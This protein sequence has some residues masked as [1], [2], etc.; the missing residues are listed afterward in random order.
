VVVGGTA[1][2]VSGTAVAG[3]APIDSPAVLVPFAASCGVTRRNA[4][5]MLPAS[6]AMNAVRPN[7][8]GRC[9][10]GYLPEDDPATVSGYLDTVRH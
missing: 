2:V 5:K 8:S 6:P 7:P 9:F 10:T 1:V 3:T 4:P